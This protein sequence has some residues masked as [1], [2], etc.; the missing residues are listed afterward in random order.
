MKADFKEYEENNVT[1]KSGGYL[2]WSQMLASNVASP[3]KVL[4]G[5]LYNNGTTVRILE[6]EEQPIRVIEER[7]SERIISD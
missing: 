5:V 6:V 1:L 3:W 7:G 2:D 4:L